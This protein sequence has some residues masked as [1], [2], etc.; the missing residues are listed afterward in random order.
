MAYVMHYSLGT[1]AQM[2]RTR[3]LHGSLCAR[4]RKVAGVRPNP[5]TF[6]YNAKASVLAARQNVLQ[7]F[8]TPWIATRLT[9]EWQ[10]TARVSLV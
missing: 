3:R 9:K 6:T 1:Q 7:S 5:A 8:V 10:P 4:L 2:M